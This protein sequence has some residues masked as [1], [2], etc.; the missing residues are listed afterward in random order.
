MSIKLKLSDFEEK[1]R[2]HVNQFLL[3]YFPNDFFDDETHELFDLPGKPLIKG[4]EIFGKYEL[5][6]IEGNSILTSD[7]LDLIKYILY[8][9]RNLPS[10][11]VILSDTKEIAAAVEKYEN[12]LDE[13]I[14]EIKDDFKSNFPNS[15]KLEVT[16]NK[17][18]QQL[19]L[20]R[21]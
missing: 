3:K 8:A 18:F 7:N 17:I 2:N 9:N 10:Q 15:T 4:P 19:N 21:Y 13:I 20:Y 11:I 16:I 12:H 1:W 14:K 6:D 5:L